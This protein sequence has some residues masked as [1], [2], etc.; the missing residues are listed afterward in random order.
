MN[1]P[2][3]HLQMASSDRALI[4]RWKEAPAPL[5]PLLHAFHDRDG[6]LSETAL[7]AVSEGLRIPLA[8]LYG[9]VTFYHH[10]SREPGG[11]QAPRVCTG[12][13]CRFHGADDVLAELDG[14]S[15]MPCSGRCDDPV[16]VLVGHDTLVAVGGE[17]VSRPPPL[18]PALA[19]GPE[20]CVFRHIRE[21]G[22]ST[23]A[24]YRATGGY[25]AWRSAV[26]EGSPD[27]V[28][29][30][31]DDS[32]LTG[33][34]G[35]GF[36]TGRKWRAVAEASGGPKTVVCNADEGEPGCFKDRALM[37]FDP[38]AVLEGMLLAA[39][40][41][42]A[43][44]GF[45][46]LRYEYPETAIILERALSEAREAGLLGE[47]ILGTELS[48]ELYLRR[49]AGAYICGEE[50]SLLNSLEGG[51][52]FPRI[53]PPYP[54]THG[55]EGTPTAV[56]NVETLASVPPI[57]RKGATWY[58]SLGLGEHA[59]TKVISLSG[60]VS[61]PGN[62]EV[63]LGLPLRT[64]LHEWAGGP[65]EGRSVQAVTMAG[66]S[67]GFLAGADLDVTLD[68][69]SIRS[70]GSFLG[71]GGIMVFDDTRDMVS[72]A[73]D[74]MAFFA[75]ESCGKCFPCR[76]GTTRL[77]ERLSGSSG[78]D[79]LEAWLDELADLHATMK[80]TS[81]CGLGQAAPL[82]TESLVRYFPT[83]VRAHVER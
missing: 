63:P 42:G 83:Q 82:I 48:I 38:H 61:R 68:E 52:P 16:P 26:L 33:R 73:R 72:V 66:L 69:P 30:A 40:A 31:I 10:F 43:S 20:E 22:R 6:H 24:G 60:D 9:T 7:R 35:A 17:M 1:R 51:H 79:D 81:A 21:Q 45:L 75:H 4:D 65:G 13:V 58:R 15:P 32:G 11:L 76:I 44:R 39:F 53:R 49:G 29:D 70:K 56:N 34:G 55:Y 37:D 23:L 14:A 71:A 25:T 2:L 27:Q 54:V 62:Y 3:I 78:P 19:E 77:V 18:P 5:L 80:S 67:G 74:A 46:Y 57:V 28:L 59:G 47:R 64:L 36:P 8:E 41:T 50:T 12:P